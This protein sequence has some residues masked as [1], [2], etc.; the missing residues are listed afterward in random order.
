MVMVKG[1]K[2]FSW[3]TH[4]LQLSEIDG[5]IPGYC[6]R[7]KEVLAGHQPITSL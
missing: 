1:S 7:Q 2:Q 5:E 6:H 3:G 4:I